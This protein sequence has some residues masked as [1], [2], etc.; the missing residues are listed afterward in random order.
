MSKATKQYKNTKL[1]IQKRKKQ[2]RNKI[3]T[4]GRILK[5]ERRR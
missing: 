5:R 2:R 1:K 3:K 4:V